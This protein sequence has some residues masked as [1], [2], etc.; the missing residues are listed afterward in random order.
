MAC[1]LL[2]FEKKLFKRSFLNFHFNVENKCICINNLKIFIIFLRT[3]DAIKTPFFAYQLFLMFFFYSF[4][5]KIL[6][7]CAYVEKGK[8]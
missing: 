3:L 5:S 8:L 6:K 4:H 7:T 1:N 2:V